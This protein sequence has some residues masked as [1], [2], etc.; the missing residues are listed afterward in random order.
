V[1]RTKQ[2]SVIIEELMRLRTHPSADELYVIVKKRLPRI[3]LG[4]VYRNL[5]LLSREGVVHRLEVGG[6]QMRFDGDPNEHQHIRCTRCG[7][8]DDLASGF[9]PSA[10]DRNVVKGTGYRVLERRVEFLGICP[11]CRKKEGVRRG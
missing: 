3:S 11:A 10:C 4:T 6:S 1:R 7:R 2:R 8:I 5:D 9:E